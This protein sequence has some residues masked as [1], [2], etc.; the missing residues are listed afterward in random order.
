MWIDQRRYFLKLL[1]S[2][3][4]DF[5]KSIPP[6]HVAWRDTIPTRFLAPIVCSKIPAQMCSSSGE[7]CSLLRLELCAPSIWSEFNKTPP[8]P[9]PLGQR[10]YVRK[11]HTR[12]VQ[13]YMFRQILKFRTFFKSKRLARLIK[14]LHTCNCIY[15][16]WRTVCLCMHSTKCMVH[17][18]IYRLFI[19]A[20]RECHVSSFQYPRLFVTSLLSFRIPRPIIKMTICPTGWL[21]SGLWAYGLMPH[22]LCAAPT[23][24]FSLARTVVFLCDSDIYHSVKQSHCLF[25]RSVPLLT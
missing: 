6:A 14:V 18:V 12:F 8:P 20:N 19:W 7:T 10:N 9:P 25:A 3:G 5:K 24:L 13:R 4:I 17:C 15:Y 2:P 21:T 1:R 16:I 23:R 11:D 22:G